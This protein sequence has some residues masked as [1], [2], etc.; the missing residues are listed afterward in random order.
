M[1][2][3]VRGFGIKGYSGIEIGSF[4]L[5][6]SS[7]VYKPVKRCVGAGVSITESDRVLPSSSLVFVGV[8]FVVAYTRE[9]V[10]TTSR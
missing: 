2:F 8:I 3:S 10:S 5:L 7:G 4:A 9:G 1:S 6:L